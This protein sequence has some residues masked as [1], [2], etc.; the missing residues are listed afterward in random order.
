MRG[1]CAVMEHVEGSRP[2]WCIS[3]MI[4]SRNTPFWSET[5]M[6]KEVVNEKAFYVVCLDGACEA[7]NVYLLEG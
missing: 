6:C 1:D 3:S 4:F 7:W 2:E 5:L